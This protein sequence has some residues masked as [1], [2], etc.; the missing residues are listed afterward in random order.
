MPDSAV[1]PCSGPRPDAPWPGLAVCA[2]TVLPCNALKTHA[3]RDHRGEQRP[4]RWRR[5]CR[6]QAD[7]NCVRRYSESLCALSTCT[8]EHLRARARTVELQPRTACPLPIWPR[9]EGGSSAPVAT[10][11]TLPLHSAELCGA[12][13]PG[14]RLMSTRPAARKGRAR[15]VLSLTQGFERQRCLIA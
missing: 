8:R 6:R 14:S 2:R 4:W 1:N 7:R 15:A 12:I 13:A 5:S 3:R 9:M 11:V 10:S